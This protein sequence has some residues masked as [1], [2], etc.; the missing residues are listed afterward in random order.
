MYISGFLLSVP[1]VPRLR[2][3]ETLLLQRGQSACVS[4]R[5]NVARTSTTSS[6]VATRCEGQ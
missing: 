4:R 2:R 3:R 1:I 5:T 6:G